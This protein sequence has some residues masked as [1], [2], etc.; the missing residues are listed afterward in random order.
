MMPARVAGE[1]GLD[2]VELSSPNLALRIALAWRVSPVPG[3][4][5]DPSGS[6]KTGAASF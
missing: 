4:A 3:L 1:N 2:Q 5:D 6:S